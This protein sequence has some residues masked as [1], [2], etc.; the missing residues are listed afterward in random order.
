MIGLV[1]VAGSVLFAP[2][3]VVIG[4]MFFGIAFADF[5]WRADRGEVLTRRS[6]IIAVVSVV[7]EGVIS[8]CLTY[9]PAL[10]TN[11]VT[12]GPNDILITV[13]TVIEFVGLL[14]LPLI[15]GYLGMG[16]WMRWRYGA[17]ARPADE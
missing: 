6:I 11:W 9:I 3:T 14:W 10:H 4:L 17:D 13:L 8:S 12:H 1:L 2:V 15:A 5:R 16:L 7:F